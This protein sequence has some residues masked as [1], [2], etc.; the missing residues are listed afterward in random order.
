[1]SKPLS[2]FLVLMVVS[3]LSLFG[4]ITGD[5][6]VRAT[7]ATG[8]AIAN[9]DVV[10]KNVETG[11]VREAK[12]DSQGAIR[13]TLL[14]TGRYEVRISAKGF[15]TLVTQ[16]EVTIGSTR[17]LKVALEVA[18]TRQEVMV[19]ESTVSINTVS[20][21]LQT[22]TNEKAV[23]E[24]P[25][26]T[27]GPLGLAGTTPGVI[28]VTPRNAFL[29]LG[30]YNSNGGRGRGNNITVDSAVSSDVSTTGGAGLGT[31]PEF[32]IRE[33]SVISNNFSAEFGRNANS[34][35]Q[36]I[37]KS[38]TND[39]H[40]QAWEF[41]RNDKMNSRD[42]FDRTGSAPI[43][44]DNR[45]GGYFGGPVVKNRFF[46]LGHYEQQKVRGQGAGSHLPDAV[47]AVEGRPVHLTDRHDHDDFA[48]GD[49]FGGGFDS[50]RLEHLHEGHHL[51]TL[52]HSGCRAAFRFADLRR[53]Q[54]A[55]RRRGFGE[56]PS[57]RD[58]QLHAHLVAYAGSER[59]GFVWPFASG[60]CAA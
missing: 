38:G 3:C 23:S 49:G 53:R 34:Q 20:S 16:A 21:Q 19:E 18:S 45:W 36:I 40:G 37:T 25:L 33:V 29:G 58:D 30:S 17:E 51:R 8:A 1:M 47:P 26:S 52:G 43:L 57:E 56:S 22:A 12:T 48:A 54:L 24:L 13:I 35:F 9:A 28:P 31:I 7:D 46:V 55:D 10:L 41:F 2:Q 4:Q 5:L 6:E 15:A 59:P 32:L 44:R 42:Y 39:F 27:L 11:A 60:L 50:R 14:N